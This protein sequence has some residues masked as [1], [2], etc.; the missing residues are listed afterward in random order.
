LQDLEAAKTLLATRDREM[1]SVGQAHYDEL[2][3]TR[4]DLAKMRSRAAGA[5][6]TARSVVQ[7]GMESAHGTGHMDYYHVLSELKA[8]IE[9]EEE[10]SGG[11]YDAM[12]FDFSQADLFG[13]AGDA[14]VGGAVRGRDAPTRTHNA[15]AYGI[16]QHPPP[17]QPSSTTP[18]AVA[19]EQITTLRLECEQLKKEA[20][21]VRVRMRMQFGSIVVLAR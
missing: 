20:A 12:D 10:D 1:R 7:R 6:R 19:L 5:C 16:Q 3:S 21:K 18:H 9:S 4:A 15:A 13:P 17:P 2:Q 14:L 11:R 8:W